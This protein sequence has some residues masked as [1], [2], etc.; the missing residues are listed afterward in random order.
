MM[1]KKDVLWLTKGNVYS[2]GYC[3]AQYL[4]GHS[5]CIGYNKGVYGWNYDIYMIGDDTIITGYRPFSA[6]KIDYS[7]LKE[8]EDEA[9]R[10]QC[11]GEE[12]TS[13]IINNLL[14]E[15]LR[16]NKELAEKTA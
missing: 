6:K 5:R 1:T 12:N 7:L 14:W 15:M 13:M 8:Y 11:R 16:V 4:L 2:I 9:R 3:Q 10:V